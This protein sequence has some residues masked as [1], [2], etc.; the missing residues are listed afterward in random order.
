MTLGSSQLPHSAARRKTGSARGGW[1]DLVPRVASGLVL[2]ALGG[3]LLGLT[4]GWLRIGAALLCGGMMWEL[5]RLTARRRVPCP[6]PAQAVLLAALTALSLLAMF[7][8]PGGWPLLLAALPIALGWG[9]MN[10]DD[11]PAYLVFVLIILIS[12]YGLVMLREQAGLATVLWIVATVVISD[13]LGYFAGRRFGGPKLWPAIS[14]NKTWSGTVAGWIGAAL[15]AVLLVLAGQAGPGAILLA[16][17]L[18][19][20]GQAGDIAES[21]LKRRVGV[22]DSSGLIPG[23]GGMMDRF[24]AMSSALIAASMM[25]ALGL[26]PAIGGQ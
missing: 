23:H 24:D 21:W 15:L 18:A 26:L 19:A 20:F 16:P 10:R 8:L 25:M 1:S 7:V 4:E 2:V 13:V 11:R 17:L 3:L 22:K 6:A 5:S 9:G 12:T 14:P